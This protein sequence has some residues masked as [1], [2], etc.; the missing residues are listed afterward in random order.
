MTIF[1]TWLRSRIG[2]DFGHVFE[3][4]IIMLPFAAFGYPLTGWIAQTAYWFGRERRDQ[5]LN[6]GINAFT[7]WYKG[8]DFWNW[9]PDGRRDLIVPIVVNGGIAL[10]IVTANTVI[11]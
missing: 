3:G 8:W 9:T 6:T 11:L 5:E 2:N 4:L 10:A 7:G 1:E